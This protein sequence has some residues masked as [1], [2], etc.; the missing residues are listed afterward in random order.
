MR[1]RQ[2]S[3][4]FSLVEMMVVVAILTVLSGLAAFGLF[5]G[6]GHARLRNGVFQAAS[7]LSLAKMHAQRSGL[8]AYVVVYQSGADFG[9]ELVESETAYA[10][11]DWVAIPGGSLPPVVGGRPVK[12]LDRLPLSRDGGYGLAA[13]SGVAA[14]VAPFQAVPH[15]GAG[16]SPALLA[17]CSFCKPASGGSAVG[18]LRFAPEGTLVVATNAGAAGGTLAFAVSDARLGTLHPTV[19]AFSAPFGAVKVY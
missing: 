13:L 18:V 6:T 2:Q 3:R 11:A 15:A 17:A 4:G 9:L 10:E 7:L 16:S 1:R 14:P 5:Y 8:Y 19:I 12:V